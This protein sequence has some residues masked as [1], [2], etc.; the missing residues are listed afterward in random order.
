MERESSVKSPKSPKAYLLFNK[1]KPDILIDTE[2]TITI[3][4]NSKKFNNNNIQTNLN[5]VMF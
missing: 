1:Q 5:D 4:D 3:N 2:T